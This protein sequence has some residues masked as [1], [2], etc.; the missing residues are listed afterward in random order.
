VCCVKN[1][2]FLEAVTVLVQTFQVLHLLLLL[3]VWRLQFY[4]C[5]FRGEIIVGFNHELLAISMLHAQCQTILTISLY[6]Q[7][8]YRSPSTA[9]VIT[10]MHPKTR[11]TSLTLFIE[12]LQE[13]WNIFPS[14]Y[15]CDIPLYYSYTMLRKLFSIIKF[16]IIHEFLYCIRIRNQQFTH[17]MPWQF[18]S[19]VVI[20]VSFRGGKSNALWNWPYTSTPF[21]AEV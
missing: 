1:I 16:I 11:F 7:L 10:I 21:N 14:V 8:S 12:F 13:Y 6:K 20:R 5:I 3:F 2:T 18:S 4:I 15:K 19:C 9:V 17:Q